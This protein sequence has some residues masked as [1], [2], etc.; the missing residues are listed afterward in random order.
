MNTHRFTYANVVTAVAVVRACDTTAERNII[1]AI[2][3][4]RDITG[5]LLKDTKDLIEMVVG[6]Q[7]AD[8]TTYRRIKDAEALFSKRT[9]GD[10]TRSNDPFRQVPFRHHEQNPLAEDYV[11]VCRVN[12]D[13]E[14][15]YTLYTREND[16]NGAARMTF[17]EAQARIRENAAE[18]STRK[19]T[20]SLYYTICRAYAT[21]SV[22]P[23]SLEP[24]FVD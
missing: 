15:E 20:R 17:D 12:D 22:V 8:N 5:L 13:P 1:P 19:G 23:V 16:M 6:R 4:L 18:Q 10:T 9:A 14:S 24:R 11:V 7:I 3:A 21:V 2:K